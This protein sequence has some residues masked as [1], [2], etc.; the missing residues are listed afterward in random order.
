MVD[1]L[2]TLAIVTIVSAI[3]LL[4]LSVIFMLY[5]LVATSIVA[6]TSGL[7]LLSAGI[8]LANLVTGRDRCR[9]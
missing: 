9:Q 2:R 4:V 6:L 7:A 3:S 1:I 5:A 8:R